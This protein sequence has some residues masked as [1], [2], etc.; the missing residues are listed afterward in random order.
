[1]NCIECTYPP[2]SPPP[3]SPPANQVEYNV[4]GVG[5]WGGT[6]TCPDGIVYQ[7]GDNGDYC[8]TLACIG[9]V[10]GPCGSNNPGGAHVRVTCAPPSPPPTPPSPPSPPPSPPPSSPSPPPSPDV[11]LVPDVT[12]GLT[13]APAFVVVTV[14]ASG[15]VSDYQN[16][17][18]ALEASFAAQAGVYPS[19]VSIVITA[20]NA[21]TAVQV[22]AASQVTTA[23]A[24]VLITATINVPAT[25]ASGVASLLS[26]RLDT[27]SV[28]SAA[29]GI[30]VTGVPSVV[31]NSPQ[32][33][34]GSNPCFPSSA[35]V[36]K[37]DGTAAR[38]DTLQEGESILAT[39]AFGALTTDTVSFL[40]IAKPSVTAEAVITLTTAANTT[41]TLTPSHHLPVGMACCQE[42]REAKDV[43][44]GDVVWVVP[45]T[46]RTPPRRGDEAVPTTV[47][48]ITRIS[49]HGGAGSLP[50]GLHSPVLTHGSYP[51]VDGV[52]TA[53]DAVGAVTLAKYG[54]PSLVAACKATGTCETVKRAIMGDLG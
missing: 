43:G 22:T 48:A 39:T 20:S 9:G 42:L 36:I 15:S 14:T 8:Q 52:V 35:L 1:V 28:A 50:R 34:S 45:K 47:S 30:P 18:S 2:P 26:S 7:V 38:I 41:L 37:S 19:Q 11:A 23:S 6:C 31:I 3:S 25:T 13:A 46:P 16:S 49:G 44:V 4:P 53:F 40:S 10:S 24:S 32:G 21:T 51:V 27:A 33:S 29:L 5:G 12:N 54:L 17:T